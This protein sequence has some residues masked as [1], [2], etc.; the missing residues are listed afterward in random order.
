MQARHLLQHLAH[1]QHLATHSALRAFA[2]PRHHR[3][4]HHLHGQLLDLLLRRWGWASRHIVDL[5][6]SRLDGF[7]KAN[8][9][10]RQSLAATTEGEIDAP[11]DCLNLLSQ[12]LHRHGSRELQIEIFSTR[13]QAFRHALAIV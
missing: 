11:Q 8:E 10:L 5:L 3:V 13:N 9:L 2:N 4:R 1:R 12:F 6:K 7:L